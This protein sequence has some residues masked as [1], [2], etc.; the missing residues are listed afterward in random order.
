M[1]D[2]G[3]IFSELVSLQFVIFFAVAALIVVL[4]VHGIRQAKRRREELAAWAAGRGLSFSDV[5]DSSFDDQY[6]EYSCLRT[7]DRRYA[8]NLMEGL[9]GSRRVTAFDYHYETSSTDSEG[10]RSTTDHHFSA[11]LV[12][13]GIPLKPLYIRREGFF[14]KIGAFFGFD[15]INFESAEFSREFCV[16]SPD[17]RWAYDVLHQRAI[18]FLLAAPRFTLDFQPRGVL[19]TG[20]GCFSTQQFDEALGV[21][22]G[23]LDMLP[24]T[25]VG[26]LKEAR[27]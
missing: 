21:V 11:V 8:Y 18:E 17:K 19:V 25:V 27:G 22:C 2:P 24:R 15:D 7:G 26:E 13:P 20:S 16:K 23:L 1:H 9:I 3:S 14:D 5:Q 12:E 6:R 4:I 10:K